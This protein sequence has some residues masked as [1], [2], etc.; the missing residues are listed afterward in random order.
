MSGSNST[1]LMNFR[2][3]SNS[4][5]SGLLLCALF[6]SYAHSQEST[7]TP[8]QTIRLNVDRVNVGVIVT[9]TKGKFVQ[10]LTRDEFHVLD[11]GVE[12]PITE[13]ASVDDPAQV[14]FLIEAGPA[15]YFLQDAHI[16]AAD[17]LLRGL[18][19]SDQ[20][21]IARYDASP[22][23]ILNFTNDKAAAQFALSGIRFNLGFGDLDLSASLA[24]VLDWLVPIPGKKTIVLL[25]TGVDTS[26]PEAV[27][28]VQA[29]L[30]SGDVRMLCVSVS[31]PMRNG[32][33]GSAKQ[34][35]KLQMDFAQ[36]DARLRA[37]AE[38]TGGRAYFPEN[39]KAI[40]DIY[41]QIAELVRNEY[42]LAF[43]PAARD[44]AVHSID[45]KVNSSKQSANEIYRVDHREAYTAPKPLS[46]Q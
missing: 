28:S 31:G 7:P 19:P 25:S 22:A 8:P 37:L 34:L 36:A 10:R 5:L 15:V 21:A 12:Q 26:S 44:G 32:K 18:T 33:K 39:A 35:Q 43:V 6:C 38:V 1:S 11:N 41:G 40:Q 16:F 23:P 29:R 17:A 27:K 2:C 9:D 20:V 4:L 3:F 42:S 14:L 46:V 30:L 24:T 13:F 45:V